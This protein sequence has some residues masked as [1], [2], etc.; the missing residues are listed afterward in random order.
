MSRRPGEGRGRAATPRVLEGLTGLLV[1]VLVVWLALSGWRFYSV[2]LLPET[3]AIPTA[4]PTIVP[5][6]TPRI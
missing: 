1:A 6:V 3:R 4:T 2:Y 5:T